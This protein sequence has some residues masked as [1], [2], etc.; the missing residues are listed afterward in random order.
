M[1]KATN[2]IN[3]NI[4]HDLAYYLEINDY[5]KDYEIYNNCDDYQQKA[6]CCN[7]IYDKFIDEAMKHD[8]YMIPDYFNDKK[9]E[10]E[11]ILQ[12]LK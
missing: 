10:I 4:V 9:E 11:N 5:L 2:A 8:L 12:E 6:N 7:V 3:I 1:N